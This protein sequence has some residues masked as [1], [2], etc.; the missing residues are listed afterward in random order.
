ME[1]KK[2]AIVYDADKTILSE[3]HPNLILR[4]RGIEVKSFWEE[5]NALCKKQKETY[6]DSNTD[7]LYLTW[8]AQR[9]ND[10]KDPLYDLTINELN[11]LGKEKLKELFY[12][13]IPN[14]FKEIKENNPG[15]KIKH[16]IVSLG[17]DHILTGGLGD[18]VD[19]IFAYTLLESKKGLIVGGT[20]SSLEKDSATKKISRGKFYGTEERGFEYHMGNMIVV[21]DGLSDKEM[22]RQVAPK[23]LAICVY[24]P[25]NERARENAIKIQ[26][27]I[28]GI[29]ISP[30]DYRKE[31]LLY[32]L[33]NNFINSKK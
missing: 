27:N 28:E 21:G 18:Y 4:A 7:C 6:P 15:V 17:I 16:N 30:A 5:V 25:F 9:S 29:K 11:K 20:N 14:F 31:G 26:R 12:P 13:G 32:E 2:I 33:I 10:P 23:G 3:D 1:N 24:D 8:L 19:R 22:F